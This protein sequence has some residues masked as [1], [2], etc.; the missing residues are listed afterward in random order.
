MKDIQSEIQPKELLK[1]QNEIR[2]LANFF[3][4]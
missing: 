1:H 3:G 4:N 2:L